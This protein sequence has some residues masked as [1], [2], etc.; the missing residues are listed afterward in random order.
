VQILS[1]ETELALGGDPKWSVQHTLILPGSLAEI[2]SILRSKGVNVFR[3]HFQQSYFA[4]IESMR[5]CVK[6]GA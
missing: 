1:I 2:V 6:S 4:E 5:P 3:E